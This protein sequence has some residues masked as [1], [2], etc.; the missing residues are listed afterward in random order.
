MKDIND[1]LY[2]L[3]HKHWPSKKVL[4]NTNMF[5]RSQETLVKVTHNLQVAH[6]LQGATLTLLRFD[7]YENTILSEV[8]LATTETKLE[9]ESLPEENICVRLQRR[10]HPSIFS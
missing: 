2:L 9:Q 7:Q 3:Y 8:N 4:K 10:R 1:F 6:P 5:N